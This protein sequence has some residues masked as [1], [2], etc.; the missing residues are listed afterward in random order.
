MRDN[1]PT[2]RTG[3]APEIIGQNGHSRGSLLREWIGSP[4][5]RAIAESLPDVIRMASRSRPP[6]SRPL[7]SHILPSSDGASG[8]SLSEVE[9]DMDLPFVHRVTIR[10]ASSWSIAPD[11]LKEEQQKRKR[12]RW[13]LRALAAGVLGV[14]GFVLARRNGVSLPARI[15]PAANLPFLST[16]TSIP[17]DHKKPGTAE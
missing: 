13:K 11:I 14:A 6:E 16:T 3:T 8:V 9:V 15:N 17:A 12:G 7:T 2:P 5:G 10:S 4:V 1:L